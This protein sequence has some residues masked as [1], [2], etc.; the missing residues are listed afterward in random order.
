MVSFHSNSENFVEELK[1]GTIQEFGIV[2]EDSISILQIHLDKNFKD[3]CYDDGCYDIILTELYIDKT[4][5]YHNYW[6]WEIS[7]LFDVSEIESF[8]EYICKGWQKNTSFG[9]VPGIEYLYDYR[10]LHEVYGDNFEKFSRIYRPLNNLWAIK[11]EKY[12]VA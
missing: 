8:W 2:Q 9:H 3:G 12:A 6:A 10:N 5:N 7:E 11:Y 4:N 1:N